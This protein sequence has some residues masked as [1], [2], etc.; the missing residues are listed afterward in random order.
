[1]ECI[2]PSHGKQKHGPLSCN[3]RLDATCSLAAVERLRQLG[4]ELDCR[5]PKPRSGGK[6]AEL[7]LAPVELIEPIAALVSPPRAHARPPAL[8]VAGAELAAQSRGD[9]HG[10]GG[11]GKAEDSS[12]SDGDAVHGRLSKG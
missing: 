4:V 12:A 5:C 10:A 2:A 7:L 8:L 9:G 3:Q 11:A 6:Q 1:M